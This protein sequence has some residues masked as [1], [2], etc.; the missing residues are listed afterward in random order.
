MNVLN[1]SKLTVK[2]DVMS[3][4]FMKSIFFSFAPEGRFRGEKDIKNDPT[5]P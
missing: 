5:T 2:L 4:Y 1:K 3:D